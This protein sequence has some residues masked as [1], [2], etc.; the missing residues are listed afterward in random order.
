MENIMS[1]INIY[2]DPDISEE[3]VEALQIEGKH[4]HTTM[5][6]YY[7]RVEEKN[8]PEI[9]FRVLLAK[10]YLKPHYYKY[11]DDVSPNNEP[12][13]YDLER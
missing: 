10:L 12:Q 1:T 13:Y 6:P 3:E 4:I 8:I 11:L 2:V 7:I 5:S 9:K